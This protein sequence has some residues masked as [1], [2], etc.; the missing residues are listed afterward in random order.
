M[1][2]KSINRHVKLIEGDFLQ[3]ELYEKYENE[4]DEDKKML[5]A[6]ELQEYNHSL[7]FEDKYLYAHIDQTLYHNRLYSDKEFSSPNAGI[8]KAWFKLIAPCS[9]LRYQ[10]IEDSAKLLIL[11]PY[12]VLREEVILKNNLANVEELI[13]SNQKS[14]AKICLEKVKIKISLDNNLQKLSQ[15]VSKLQKKLD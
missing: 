9:Y 2:S 3:Q 1:S 6:L 12:S 7:G 13:K 4:T 8:Y 11:E 5:A 14:D 10:D 15:Q